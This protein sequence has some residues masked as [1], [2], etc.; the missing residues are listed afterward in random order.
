MD[1]DDDDS[2]EDDDDDDDDDDEEEDE[3]EEEKEEEEEGERE[4]LHKS[5]EKI[6][7][8]N[9]IVFYPIMNIPVTTIIERLAYFVLYY[10]LI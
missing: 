5:V 9:L 2:D 7:L 1:D 10:N 4:A 3:E 6:L 8:Q